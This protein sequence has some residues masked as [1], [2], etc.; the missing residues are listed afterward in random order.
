MQDMSTQFKKPVWELHAR[1]IG[2]THEPWEPRAVEARSAI[3]A[4]AILR[5]DGY[6]SILMSARRVDKI[7]DPRTPAKLKDPRC[8]RCGYQLSGLVI[9][10]S[11][12]V[13]PE[14]AFRQPVIVWHPDAAL[15]KD[16][17]SGILM[18]FAIIGMITVT[19]FLVLLAFAIL[20]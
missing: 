8:S 3:Q 7:P 13:C 11:V 1:P 16:S 4:E 5:R 15:K 10:E 18:V 9:E 12:V 2:A 20:L 6:E 19:L 17:G 14:C